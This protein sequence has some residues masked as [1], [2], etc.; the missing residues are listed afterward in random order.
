MTPRKKYS[1]WIDDHQAD[2]LKEVKER[3]GVLESEQIRR[4]IN[5]WLEKKGV[6]KKM[7]RPRAATRRR[8][9]R[10]R[11]RYRWLPG[12]RRRAMARG[13][14]D[15]GTRC[16]SEV[17]R[18][19]GEGMPPA[20]D[21]HVLVYSQPQEQHAIARYVETARGRYHFVATGLS[22]EEI[23]HW[24]YLDTSEDEEEE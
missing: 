12:V 17:W 8:S 14:L 3:D 6:R 19:V 15:D 21:E 2:G 9:G 16:M 22:P 18:R 4:A 24:R 23:T 1:F 11:T 5:D 20:V 10:H 13:V 7:E